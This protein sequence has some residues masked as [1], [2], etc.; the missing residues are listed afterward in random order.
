MEGSDNEFQSRLQR[1]APR[2]LPLQVKNAT[3]SAE[4]N[5]APMSVGR[6]L[7][8]SGSSSVT[9]T[10]FSSSSF[11]SYY[12]NKDPIPLCSLHQYCCLLCQSLPIFKREI[13][14]NLIDFHEVF[15]LMQMRLILCMLVLI[16]WS[17]T[18]MYI[19]HILLILQE[20]TSILCTVLPF[21]HN[22]FLISW[23]QLYKN[24]YF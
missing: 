3:S 14:R 9:I 4:G 24:L 7:E 16:A 15:V 10:T 1:R 6:N 21:A 17:S 11:A 22:N 20:F 13:Q 19:Q 18:L 8:S 2:P 23:S 5:G 12:H